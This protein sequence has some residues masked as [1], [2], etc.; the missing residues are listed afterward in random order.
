MLKVCN[1]SVL[2]RMFREN[3]RKEK[4]WFEIEKEGQ[5]REKYKE[6]KEISREMFWEILSMVQRNI[7]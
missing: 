2:G 4:V 5:H 3:K 7:G 1:L 6:K